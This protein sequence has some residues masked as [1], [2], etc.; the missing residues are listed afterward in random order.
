VTVF[1]GDLQAGTVRPDAV[2]HA[3]VVEGQGP[4]L[5][6]GAAGVIN[7]DCRG[8]PIR[9]RTCILGEGGGYRT[10]LLRIRDLIVVDQV[11]EILQEIDA[12]ADLVNQRERV[13]VSAVLAFVARIG[14]HG[15]K[16]IGTSSGSC[17]AC[18]DLR[19]S[20]F[21]GNQPVQERENILACCT[22]VMLA[23]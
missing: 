2:D 3:A 22:V 15:V 16:V 10:R 8:I 20:V 11:L 21:V 6:I 19:K 12:L 9:S 17:W 4:I 23:D 18:S 5:N 14:I 13:A 7:C 1:I